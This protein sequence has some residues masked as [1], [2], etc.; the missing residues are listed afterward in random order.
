MNRLSPVIN[1]ITECVS[2]FKAK[3]LPCFY[4]LSSA[5]AVLSVVKLAYPFLKVKKIVDLPGFE[6]GTSPKLDGAL[7]QTELKVNL[8]SHP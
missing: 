8:I 6:P 1:S 3:G 7:Y 5:T 2:P 4:S